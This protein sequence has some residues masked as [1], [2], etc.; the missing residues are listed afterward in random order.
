MSWPLLEIALDQCQSLRKSRLLRF[1]TFF[2]NLSHCKY[3]LILWIKY[4]FK[5]VQCSHS[6]PLSRINWKG[7]VQT[8]IFPWYHCSAFFSNSHKIL[9]FTNLLNFAQA[10]NIKLFF[11]RDLALLS[12]SYKSKSCS[13][14]HF[15]KFTKNFTKRLFKY[16]LQSQ[17]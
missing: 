7:F 15:L 8:T 5:Y 12:R 2:K 4:F 9:R 10:Y 1:A 3:I 14:R 11:D 13:L 17:M 6:N 16:S